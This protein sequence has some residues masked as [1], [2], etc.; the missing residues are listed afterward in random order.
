MRAW[1]FGV[2]LLAVLLPGG[3][4]QPADERRAGAAAATGASAASAAATPSGERAPTGLP[5]VQMPLLPARPA[6]PSLPKG[7]ALP[8][9]LPSMKLPALKPPALPSVTINPTLTVVL[10]GAEVPPPAP[11]ASASAPASSASPPSPSPRPAPRPPALTVQGAAEAG[12]QPIPQPSA[13]TAVPLP[14]LTA[15]SAAGTVTSA[16]SAAPGG[17]PGDLPLTLRYQT[18]A[19]PGAVEGQRYGPRL[20]AWGGQPPYEMKL[21][22]GSLPPGLQLTP[23]GELRGVP[24]ALARGRRHHPFELEVRDAQGQLRRQAYAI[25]VAPPRKATPPQEPASEPLA[26]PREEV[27]EAPPPR[28]LTRITVYRLTEAKLEALLKEVTP[29]MGAPAPAAPASA[30]SSAA[31]PAPEDPPTADELP[32]TA[33]EL[34]QGLRLLG[35]PAGQARGGATAASSADASAGEADAA[36]PIPATERPWQAAEFKAL[37]TPLLDTDYPSRALF[38]AALRQQRCQFWDEKLRRAAKSMPKLAGLN[39]RAMLRAPIEASPPGRWTPKA[40]FDSLLPEALVPRVVKAA[41]EP[42][43]LGASKGLAWR[44][45]RCG[46]VHPLREDTL[47]VLL[48]YWQADPKSPLAAAA[49]D[50]SPFHQVHLLGAVLQDSGR[51][52]MPAHWDRDLPRFALTAREHDTQLQLVVHRQEWASLLGASADEQ[53]RFVDGAVRAMLAELERPALRPLP[54]AF[55]PHWQRHHFLYKGLTLW[56]DETPPP[57]HPAAARFHALTRELVNALADAMRALER[58]LTLTLAVPDQLFGQPGAF[59]IEDLVAYLEHR[60]A[61]EPPAAV[62]EGFE[63]PKLPLRVNLLLLLREPASAAKKELRALIDRSEVV[64]GSR[65]IHLLNHTLPLVIARSRLTPEEL[66]PLKQLDD[67]IAYHEWVYGGLALGALPRVS[68]PTAANDGELLKRLREHFSSELHWSEL[69]AACAWVCPNR[70]AFR[71][72][73]ELTLLACALCGAVLLFS[74][75]AS[76]G[77]AMVKLLLLMPLA[78]AALIGFALLSCDPQWVGLRRGAWPIVL[79]GAVLLGLVFWRMLRRQ[80]P[81]P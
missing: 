81:A 54:R 23:G 65:R 35:L 53:R 51:L 41:R 59:R 12:V 68:G 15:T 18:V 5:G 63:A 6:L 16:A 64:K 8:I 56:F 69:P 57:G 78:L 24:L 67:D 58:P 34:Q 9:P 11:A 76:D 30:A 45:A 80:V 36:A 1:L 40:L 70:D 50:F 44:A 19:L 21:L 7:Q 48:P 20:L 73:F 3:T 75:R 33:E 49:V 62:P 26:L 72:A 52:L 14:P 60:K 32:F 74:E 31:G 2:P 28:E 38:E 39:C 10:P 55:L 77:G 43:E 37:L 25:W 13:P 22:R 46:C 47:A 71:L 4:A 42:M 29:L 27:D 79:P 66:Q 61:E 17:A